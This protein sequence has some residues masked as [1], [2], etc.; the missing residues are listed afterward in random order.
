MAR[1]GIELEELVPSALVAAAEHGE[2]DAGPMPLAASFHLEAR[3][4]P[5]AGF[6][7][8]GA[9][10]AG[11]LFLYSTV[12]IAELHGAHI[13][14]SDEAS[15]AP[16]LLEILLRLRYGVQ[17][18]GYVPLT[19]SHDGLLLV[20]NEALRQRLGV[21]GFR[22]T[23]DLGAEWYAW[24][25][26]PYVFSRWMVRRDV[27]PKDLALLVDTLYVGLEE[28]VN[29]LYGV[30]DPR[31]DLLMLPRDIVTYIQGLRYHIGHAEQRA[32]EQF[33]RY[34]NELQSSRLQASH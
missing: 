33:Q 31:E 28:G 20:G 24:T 16:S 15:S 7:V 2:I 6:C 17:P 32:I 14:V 34:L 1:R 4:Q 11:S 27:A 25:G 10:Q 13:A 5:V 23:Y 29:A 21:P 9:R 19:A 18:N 3:F 8:A 22:H 30:A 12:P 26:L